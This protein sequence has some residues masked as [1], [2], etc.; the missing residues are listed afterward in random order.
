MAL[1]PKDGKRGLPMNAQPKKW[2]PETQ[3]GSFLGLTFRQSH[4]GVIVSNGAN[5]H[6]VRLLEFFLKSVG[7]TTFTLSVLALVSISGSSF[8]NSLLLKLLPTALSSFGLGL[9]CF[10]S[11]GLV[12]EVQID[13]ARREIRIGTRNSRGVVSPTRVA[14]L[15]E[16]QSIFIRRSNQKK[17]LV[18]LQI[19][20]KSG[21]HTIT[22]LHG[23]ERELTSILT[24]IVDLNTN[25][26]KRP[27]TKTT[28]R[29]IRAD[30]SSS[31]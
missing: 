28:G 2:A 18:T 19:R 7:F 8:I 22:L 3:S 11:K 23:K 26:R 12:T 27:R 24:Y 15:N 10:A 5:A 20:L 6:K 17:A 29:F 13:N 31:W 9:F 4:W 25:S 21:G 30:F 1:R 14:P 16:I